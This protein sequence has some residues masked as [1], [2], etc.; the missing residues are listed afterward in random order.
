MMCVAMPAEDTASL[1]PPQGAVWAANGADEATSESLPA[2]V[3]LDEVA[4]GR[5]RRRIHR[6]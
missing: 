4:I 6:G 5:R 3:D 2:M 1:A